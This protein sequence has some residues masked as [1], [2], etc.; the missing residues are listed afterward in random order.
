MALFGPFGA[1]LLHVLPHVSQYEAST[2]MVVIAPSP[3]GMRA[4]TIAVLADDVPPGRMST[5]GTIPISGLNKQHA[6]SGSNYELLVPDVFVPA[7]L[8]PSDFNPPVT[9]V[10]NLAQ[11]GQMQI[12]ILDVNYETNAV[13]FA[14]P[15]A[16]LQVNGRWV[17]QKEIERSRTTARTHAHP[18]H[19]QPLPIDYH[20]RTKIL[21]YAM[22]YLSLCPTLCYIYLYLTIYLLCIRSAGL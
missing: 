2:N 9:S 6:T 3:D 20:Y 14:R 18:I 19:T 21:T 12:V 4:G 15:A 11:P 10:N 1:L 13:S 16:L 8:R 7:S 17:S 5:G 22:L